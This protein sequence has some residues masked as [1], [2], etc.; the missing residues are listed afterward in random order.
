LAWSGCSTRAPHRISTPQ[1]SRSLK[2]LEG[3]GVIEYL[4][5]V[6]EAFRQY[7]FAETSHFW[8]Q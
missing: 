7:G 4:S 6:R 3:G 8:M 2:R 1:S 5:P